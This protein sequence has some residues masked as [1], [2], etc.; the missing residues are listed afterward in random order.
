MLR[1][2]CHEVCVESTVHLVTKYCYLELPL[3]VVYANTHFSLVQ[4]ITFVSYHLDKL[5]CSEFPKIRIMCD[6]C[7][8][9]PLGFDTEHKSKCSSITG[10]ISASHE[11]GIYI[12]FYLTSIDIV[13]L[14][15]TYLVIYLVL[16]IIQHQ[17]ISK[18][19]ST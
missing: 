4:N 15:A 5:M 18:L 8:H 9:H 12:S 1:W 6:G 19:F 14:P 17:P 13:R 2:E 10:S 16:P 7:S 11:W 3:I